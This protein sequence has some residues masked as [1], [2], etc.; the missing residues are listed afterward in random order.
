MT[1][2]ARTPPCPAATF[3]GAN[4]GQTSAKGSRGGAAE[5][6]ATPLSHGSPAARRETHGQCCRGRAQRPAHPSVFRPDLEQ[7]FRGPGMVP[8]APLRAGAEDAEAPR[9][10]PPPPSPAVPGR[11]PYLDGPRGLALDVVGHRRRLVHDAGG[12]RG[13]P[14][15]APAPAAPLPGAPRQLRP[16]G[17][18]RPLCPARH[19]PA[20]PPGAGTAIGAEPKRGQSRIARTRCAPPLAPWARAAEAERDQPRSVKDKPPQCSYPKSVRLQQKVYAGCFFLCVPRR[21]FPFLLSPFPSTAS[22]SHS[23]T[24]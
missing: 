13:S 11:R 14:A 21:F 10:R 9:C 22:S 2:K 23:K 18:A 7:T 3:S 17:V 20:T 5:S 15:A 4:F 8:T 19:R 12:A 6:T 1:R 24:T 16:A